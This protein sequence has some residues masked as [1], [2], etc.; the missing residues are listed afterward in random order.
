[1]LRFAIEYFIKEKKQSYHFILTMMGSLLALNIVLAMYYDPLLSPFYYDGLAGYFDNIYQMVIIFLV[2]FAF[3]CLIIDTCQYYN[4]IHSKILGLL[5]IFGYSTKEIVFFFLIQLSMIFI[6]AFVLYSIFNIPLI[7]LILQLIYTVL[8]KNYIFTFWNKAF[9]ETVAIL[10]MLLIM[11]LMME[12]MYVIQNP[13][14]QLLKKDQ[15]ISFTMKKNHFIRQIL[16]ISLFGY[17][18]YILIIEKLSLSGFVAVSLC[19]IGLSGILKYTIP[20]VVSWMLKKTDIKAEMLVVWKNVIFLLKSM[21]TVIVFT[22]IVNVVI[23]FYVYIFINQ[24]GSFIE[25]MIILC[26]INM[27]I[28]Y[29]IYLK[30]KMYIMKKDYNQ[31]LYVLGYSKKEIK[32]YR[33]LEMTLFYLITGILISIYPLLLLIAMYRLNVFNVL[34]IYVWL[35]YIVPLFVSYLFVCSREG[36]EK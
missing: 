19:A 23:Q 21:N 9:F 32:K 18:I 7:V 3:G 6:A 16:S 22:L 15:I 11:L 29:F 2:L 27:V 33:R 28:G 4:K 30:L 20:D 13:I 8:D 17:G 24:L 25:Y 1:M 14:V 12:M 5:K 31:N 34:W 36:G 10:F 26:I 35:G